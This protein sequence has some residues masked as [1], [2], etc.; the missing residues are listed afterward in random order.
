MAFAFKIWDQANDGQT[1]AIRVENTNELRRLSRECTG[2]D[3]AGN[4]D[5]LADYLDHARTA[6][7]EPIPYVRNVD[8]LWTN[9]AIVLP[10]QYSQDRRFRVTYTGRVRTRGGFA[11]QGYCVLDPAWNGALQP[12]HQQPITVEWYSGDLRDLVVVRP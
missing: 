8:V 12:H 6:T 5:S 2:P 3:A 9:P 10:N 7:A 4:W 1:M 11:S